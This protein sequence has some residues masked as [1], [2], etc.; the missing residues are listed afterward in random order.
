MGG[1]RHAVRLGFRQVMGF[2]EKDARSLVASRQSGYAAPRELWRR[3][4]M[5]AGALEKL[6]QAD[7]FRSL[8]LDRRQALWALK[9]LGAPPLP[10]FAAAADPAQ[11]AAPEAALPEMTLGEAVSEDY[12]HLPPIPEGPPVCFLRDAAGDSGSVLPT[13]ALSGFARKARGPRRRARP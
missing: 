4:G 10:L 5:S 8:G 6:A 11:R 2:S 7:A 1:H 9:G 3:G 12:S 13:I